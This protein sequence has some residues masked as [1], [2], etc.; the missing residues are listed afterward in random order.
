MPVI[1]ATASYALRSL[2]CALLLLAR[3]LIAT[4]H[5]SHAEFAE[6]TRVIEGELVSVAWRNP[7]PAMTLRVANGSEE[8]LWR[9]QVLGNVNGLRRDGVTGEGFE[10]GRRVRV[11]G[12]P[13][14]RREGVLLAVSARFEDGTRTTAHPR[15]TRWKSW[16]VSHSA[17]MAEASIG[18]RR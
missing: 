1:D 7:H 14:D 9:I 12:H 6:D 16:N 8:A 4:A 15:A 13:S 10:V 17:P 5:H 2:T 18:S 11:T 3:P